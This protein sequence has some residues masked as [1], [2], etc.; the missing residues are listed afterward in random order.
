MP[1]TFLHG[2][3][4]T[5][6]IASWSHLSCCSILLTSHTLNTPSAVPT[7]RHRCL[8][9][10]AT[11]RTCIILYNGAED[12]GLARTFSP[13]GTNS[14][15]LCSSRSDRRLQTPCSEFTRKCTRQSMTNSMQLAAPPVAMQRISAGP[16]EAA[17]PYRISDLIRK[18]WD[19]SHD[20]GQFR[21]FLAE[22]HLWM[23]AWS[24]QGERIVVRVESVD[25]VDR[26][27]HLKPLCARFLHRTTTN[28]PLRMVQQVQGER[29]QGGAIQLA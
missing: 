1:S 9:L 22:L 19:G 18:S 25:K 2:T 29:G 14:C 15:V 21:N 17:K 8:S 27:E 20:K 28:E 26:S 11:L 5:L 3:P 6:L 10:P 4:I 13:S 24:D 16:A 12:T 7:S 23:Q